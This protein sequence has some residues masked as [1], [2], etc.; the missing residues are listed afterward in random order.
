MNKTIEDLEFL[1]SCITLL[2]NSN[3]LNM[4]I[5]C[6][7]AFEDYLYHIKNNIKEMKQCQKL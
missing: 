4:P 1:V 2:L 6:Y 3:K 5:E 7:R